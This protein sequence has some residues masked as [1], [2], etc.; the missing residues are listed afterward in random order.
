MSDGGAPSAPERARRG[1]HPIDHRSANE[2]G[3]STVAV[4][5]FDHLTQIGRDADPVHLAATTVS[6]P[7]IIDDSLQ[8]RPVIALVRGCIHE[9]VM[10]ECHAP[11][12]SD[13]RHTG[14]PPSMEV[15]SVRRG[16]AASGKFPRSVL[17]LV[18]ASRMRRGGPTMGPW[19][20][21]PV[22]GSRRCGERSQVSA[23]HPVKG[24]SGTAAS[25]PCSIPSSR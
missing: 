13:W 24:R 6:S 25:V 8:E 10:V 19:H 4:G 15:M 23:P 14:A 17:H 2:S 3:V 7:D 1:N 11:R 21:S 18:R 20:S 12:P 16:I 22:S 9:V 5:L